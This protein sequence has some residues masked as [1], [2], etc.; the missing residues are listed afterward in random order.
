MI[1][2]IVSFRLQLMQNGIH[3]APLLISLAKKRKV[4]L[5]DSFSGTGGIAARSMR[6]FS[7]SCSEREEKHYEGVILHKD[8]SNAA[9]DN[10]VV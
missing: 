2:E 4:Q 7:F 3:R 1:D 10:G 6:D 5:G 8:P 9:D